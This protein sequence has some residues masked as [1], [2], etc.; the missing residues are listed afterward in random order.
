MHPVIVASFTSAGWLA[1]SFLI[2]KLFPL[3]DWRWGIA[4]IFF[5]SAAAG[6]QWHSVRRG[7]KTKQAYGRRLAQRIMRAR[8]MKEVERLFDDFSTLPPEA[9]DLEVYAAYGLR[10]WR[11]GTADGGWMLAGVEEMAV[12][13]GRGSHD[14]FLAA[15]KT[16]DCQFPERWWSKWARKRRDRREE[17]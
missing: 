9:G 7:L 2:E 1:L 14:D 4:A 6:A 15:I 12:E 8:S 17:D 5:F 11:L 16:L 13:G 10:H 3:G